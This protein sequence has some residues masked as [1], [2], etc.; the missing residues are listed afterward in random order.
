MLVGCLGLND[1]EGE[2][3]SVREEIVGFLSWP[4]GV[5]STDY[6]DAAG[7]KIALLVDLV[8]RPPRVAELWDNVHATGVGFGGSHGQRLRMR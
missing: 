4:T 5:P 7:G 1:G 8:V 2:V 6:Y 3:W